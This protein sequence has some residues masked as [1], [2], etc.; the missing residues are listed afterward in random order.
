M[1]EG[2]VQKEMQSGREDYEINHVTGRVNTLDKSSSFSP[3]L[4]SL[5]APP[6]S[7]FRNLKAQEVVIN[8][9]S[10]SEE[11]KV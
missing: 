10:A 11:K 7:L 1:W 5:P 6:L 4:S 2:Q 3:F 8:L 9:L